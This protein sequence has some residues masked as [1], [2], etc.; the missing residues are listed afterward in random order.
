MQSKTTKLNEQKKMFFTTSDLLQRL[1]LSINESVGEDAPTNGFE[2]QRQMPDGSYR[3]AEEKELAAAN[4][5][6]KM[7]Q[8]RSLHDAIVF[9]S[10]VRNY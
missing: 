1:N 7:K 8:V 10:S 6:T 3:R 5:Q 4:F 9:S 2:L